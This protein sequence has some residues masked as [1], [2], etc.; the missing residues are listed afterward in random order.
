M[1][2]SGKV[3]DGDHTV[4][5]PD[6]GVLDCQPYR[7]DTNGE[8]KSCVSVEDCVGP[9]V[10]DGNGKCVDRPTHEFALTSGCGVGRSGEGRAGLAA[11]VLAALAIAARVR[12]HRSL[13]ALALAFVGAAACSAQP[14]EK[15]WIEATSSTTAVASV[16]ARTLADRVRLGLRQIGGDPPL[17]RLATPA[18]QVVERDGIELRP[19]F[20][21]GVIHPATLSLPVRASGAFRIMDVDS[22]LSAEVSL[23]GAL[24][25][26]GEV[27]AGFVVYRRGYHGGAHLVHRPTPWG[28]EDDLYLE[29]APGAPE[30]RYRVTLGDT[31]A[32][33][34]LVANT[35]ELLDETGTPRLRMAPPF[36]VDGSGGRHAAEI[37]VHGCAHDTD[38]RPPWGR[39]VTAPGTR[40]CT[41]DIRWGEM[42]YPAVVDPLWTT[43]G[44]VVH[45][46]TSHTA[47][48]LLD[49]RVLVAGGEY[50]FDQAEV[51][52]P[53]TD[54]WAA[55]GNLTASRSKHVAAVLVDGRVL[56]A[57]GCNASSYC[58]NGLNTVN[59]TAEIYDPGTGVWSP[60]GSMSRDRFDGK[61]SLLPG[62][63]VLIAGGVSETWKYYLETAE[64]YDPA[65]G[66][67]SVTNSMAHKRTRHSMSALHDGRIL[68]TGGLCDNYICGELYLSS[69]ELYDPGAGAW[70]DAGSMSI[71]RYSHTAS[72]L[73]DGRVL[74]SGGAEAGASAEVYDPLAITWTL[75]AAMA[76]PRDRHTATVLLDGRVLVTGSGSN[77]GL[78]AE[79]FDP[80]TGA[81]SGA[82][83]MNGGYR[84]DHTANLLANGQVLVVGGTLSPSAPQAELFEL[85]HV[86]EACT[87]PGQCKSGICADGV[88]CSAPC[89]GICR[90][91]AAAKTGVADGT[92][93]P[94][95]VG[96]DPNG[97]CPDQGTGSCGFDGACDGA[98]A[99]RRYA[100]GSGCGTPSC[101]NG[102]R[103]TGQCDGAGHCVAQVKSCAPYLCANVTACASQCTQDAQCIPAHFC[104]NNLCQP[105]Q[106]EGQPCANAAQC[107]SG[108]C[109]DGRCCED[110]C[111]APCFACSQA[112]TGAADGKCRPASAGID[113]HQDCPDD[114][115]LSCKRDGAC[116]GSGGCR[117]YAAGTT[118]DVAV[119]M[120]I[121]AFA[122]FQC[123]GVGHCGVASFVC[124]GQY[125][126]LDGACK[127]SCLSDADCLPAAWCAAGKCQPK[128]PSGLHACALDHECETEICADGYC[129]NAP[130]QGQCEACDVPG[131]EGTCVALTPV[132]PPEDHARPACT[133]KQPD[134]PCSQTRCDGVER[135]EC[136]GYIGQEDAFLCR[137]ASCVAGVAV[138]PVHCDGQGHCP[139]VAPDNT[140]LCEPFVCGA[141]ACLTTCTTNTDCVGGYH[142]DLDHGMCA[143]WACDGAHTVAKTDGTTLDCGAFK[144]TPDGRCPTECRSVDD[145][146]TPFACDEMH[147]CVPRPDATGAGCT[148]APV[149][150]LGHPGALALAL[151]ALGA[152]RTRTARRGSAS[153][154]PRR[155]S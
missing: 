101:S 9:F 138:V 35:L 62:G 87:Q 31:V 119:C 88:C 152:F 130:C 150:R 94:V 45:A 111:T 18:A 60:T 17:D 96:T 46:R 118:C 145:C 63:K 25:V 108:F 47:S 57:G 133:R 115:A 38:P 97:Q 125:R 37:F 147:R 135:K 3:C 114:G 148:M 39:A 80:S 29:D 85:L 41:V 26:E 127:M 24:D 99:C 51:Y 71:K 23:D 34:R 69:A 33:L 28:T 120:G 64:L 8:C 20:S 67:W 73:S 36:V 121:D 154:G 6:G 112:T 142:C 106:Q 100:A 43:T 107:Q 144:C 105:D 49:G 65:T 42:R 109:V 132:T 40:K 10:C 22:G 89:A 27:V 56:V 30:A 77:S 4:M 117:L 149:A 84:I 1:C 116:D 70:S 61:A 151:V 82:G 124:G 136:A 140:V 19:R 90:A 32:G 59:Q 13:L 86:G 76:E 123:D 16:E 53:A 83:S 21:S 131:H 81:W 74:V 52:D 7:C 11:L 139:A 104:A 98:G 146:V 2:V 75:A 143:P 58:G 55:T 95:I 110:S 102:Q 113:P 54:T 72:V 103:I 92:C 79:L 78:D 122:Q 5:M 153:R 50:A 93:A 15:P 126:C 48:T 12:R 66:T 128:S 44:Q 141:G 129:C 68:V 14:Q 91:C 155:G 134:D 137:Q